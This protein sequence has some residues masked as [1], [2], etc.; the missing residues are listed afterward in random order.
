MSPRPSLNVTDFLKL[1][2]LVHEGQ[3]QQLAH[4]TPTVFNLRKKKIFVRA[5]Q[6]N[7]GAKSARATMH[8]EVRG[9]RRGIGAS[10]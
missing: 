1:D 9:V 4:C 8:D 7:G 3:M 10:G 6:C 5:C 2:S